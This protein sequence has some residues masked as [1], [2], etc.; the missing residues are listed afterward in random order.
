MEITTV[1]ITVIACVWWLSTGWSSYCMYQQLQMQ[2]EWV[3]SEQ[4]NLER[5]QQ[6]SSN[7]EAGWSREKHQ[8]Y[9]PTLH[10]HP[11]IHCLTCCCFCCCLPRHTIPYTHTMKVGMF[12]GLVFSPSQGTQIICSHTQSQSLIGVCLIRQL[13]LWWQALLLMY[14]YSWM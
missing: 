2:K 5:I 14:E 8:D 6:H 11:S 12:P 10:L 13:D 9:A 7:F 3:T 1:M 4:P